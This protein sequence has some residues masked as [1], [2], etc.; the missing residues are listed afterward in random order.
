MNKLLTHLPRLCAYSASFLL[1][2]AIWPMPEGYYTFLRFALVV[3]T[4]ALII[5]LHSKKISRHLLILIAIA[6]LF[7]PIFPFHFSRGLWIAVD[8][9]V[10]IY[11]A[12]TAK[13]LIS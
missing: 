2:L 6:L 13:T 8:V 4:L 5:Q 7:N 12:L 9:I 11:F 10:A 1:L 3:I